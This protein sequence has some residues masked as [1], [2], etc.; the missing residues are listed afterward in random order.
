[1]SALLL[2]LANRKTQQ[3][4]YGG[5]A[6]I[7][8]LSKERVDIETRNQSRAKPETKPTPF[9]INLLKRRAYNLKKRFQRQ[10]YGREWYKKNRDR[11]NKQSNL[12]KQKNRQRFY[13]LQKEWR[14]KNPEKVK[15]YNKKKY[16]RR[17]A[18]MTPAEFKVYTRE[19]YLKAKAKKIAE[20]GIEAYRAQNNARMRKHYATKKQESLCQ[21][22]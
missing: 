21:L 13:Q 17:K 22:S 10:Q 2:A 7:D 5:L 6:F 4:H 11:K 18:S 12:W 15:Q 19:K 1:M 3:K 8:E 20:I 16:E 9:E 14:K